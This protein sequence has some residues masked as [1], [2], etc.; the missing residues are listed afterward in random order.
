[1]DVRRSRKNARSGRREVRISPEGLLLGA[2]FHAW[3]ASGNRLEEFV[4]EEGPPLQIRIRYSSPGGKQ[5]RVDTVVFVPVPT[6]S[7]AEAMAVTQKLGNSRKSQYPN[8]S[9]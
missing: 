6:N 7:K 3:G 8:R 5:A 1:M 4:V 9:H 2:E